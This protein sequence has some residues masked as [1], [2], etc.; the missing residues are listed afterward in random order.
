MT[1]KLLF[2]LHSLDMNSTSSILRAVKYGEGKS[3]W[4][5]KIFCFPSCKNHFAIIILSDCR[6]LFPIKWFQYSFLNNGNWEVFPWIWK[7][8][9]FTWSCYSVL[10]EFF[11]SICAI[12]LK[13]FINSFN[14]L[15]N[16][17]PLCTA[18][19]ICIF[20]KLHMSNSVLTEHRVPCCWNIDLGCQRCKSK[21]LGKP[22]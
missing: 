14:W 11:F 18:H 9:R 10:Q 1:L 5:G 20:W 22:K 8:N 19:C 13:L 12:Q 4:V 3:R 16:Y 2:C 7:V 6:Q 17:S 15:H 21:E